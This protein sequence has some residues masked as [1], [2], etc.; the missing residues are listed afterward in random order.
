MGELTESRNTQGSAGADADQD[1]DVDL[2]EALDLNTQLVNRLLRNDYASL[3]PERRWL[4]VDLRGVQ[5]NRF[6]VGAQIRVVTGSTR[7][8]REVTAGSGS[9]SQNELTAHFGLGAATQAD[10]VIVRWPSGIVQV[11]R[12]VPADQRITI[13]EFDQTG[14]AEPGSVAVFAGLRLLAASPNPFRGT[15]TISFSLEKG[16]TVRVRIFDALGRSVRALEDSRWRASGTHDLTWDGRDEAGR[17]VPGGV[18]FVSVE[19]GAS[20]EAQKLVLYR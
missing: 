12:N 3:F 17:P 1:G 18:F 8:M 15:T 5:S 14:V 10:T 13:T 2:Y 6:G 16:A 19:A 11:L 9:F 20:R 4:L 7:Q